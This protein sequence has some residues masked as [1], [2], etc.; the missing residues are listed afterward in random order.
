MPHG[1]AKFD[2]RVV[3]QVAEI[4]RRD[5]YQ[6]VHAHTA[7]SAI[8]A[9]LASWRAGVPM[10][11]HVHSPTA[12]DTTNRLRNWLNV[13]IERFSLSGVARLI[14]VSESLGRHM[15]AQGYSA[16]RISVV[17]NGVPGI[18]PLSRS[19]DA[20]RTANGQLGTVALMR[21]RK[22]IEVLI[23]ALALLR[24]QNL[25]GATASRPSSSKT[26]P[27]KRRQRNAWPGTNWNRSSIGPAS[28]AT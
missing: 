14:T 10:V 26:P 27:M 11:Y 6:M 7:R 21:P 24:K 5:S 2:L 13:A 16:D 1:G 9:R 8:V 28:R 3:S 19:H 23:D 25:A 4:I 20:A 12:R 22:G 15:R 17:H 18:S